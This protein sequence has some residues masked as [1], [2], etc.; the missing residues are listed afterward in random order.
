MIPEVIELEKKKAQ[1]D[2]EKAGIIAKHEMKQTLDEAKGLD[3]EQQNAVKV[4]ATKEY[5]QA[6]E[7]AN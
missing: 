2:Y 7:R 1:I 4:L 6:R 5:E 3:K